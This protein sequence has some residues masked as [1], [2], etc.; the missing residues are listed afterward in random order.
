MVSSTDFSDKF[1]I[2][3]LD[4]R[5][6][7]DLNVMRQFTCQVINSIMVDNFAAFFNCTPVDRAS[8]SLMTLP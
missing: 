6:G 2:I 1:R 8:D 5:I 4:K 3:I 7:Y